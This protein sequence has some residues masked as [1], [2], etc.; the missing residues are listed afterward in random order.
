MRIASVTP[1]ATAD[2]AQSAYPTA[3]KSSW[4][5]SLIL[6]GLSDLSDL[7][8]VTCGPMFQVLIRGM[9]M[10]HCSPSGA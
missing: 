1:E 5:R 2:V 7:S 6:H 10:T 8:P 4:S 9:V 3:S